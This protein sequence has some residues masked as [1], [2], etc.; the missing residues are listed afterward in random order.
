MDHVLIFNQKVLVPVKADV[1]QEDG[2]VCI[3]SCNWMRWL[4]FSNI[5]RVLTVC[6]HSLSEFDIV[7]G[8]HQ[9]IFTISE[10]TSKPFH[11]HKSVDAG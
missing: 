7:N 6:H 2:N 11:T 1:I 9:I 10:T 3:Y 5:V 4:L 8:A